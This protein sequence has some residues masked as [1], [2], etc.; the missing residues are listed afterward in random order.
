MD[1]AVDKSEFSTAPHVDFSSLLFLTR[2][3]CVLFTHISPKSGVSRSF[4]SF[5]PHGFAG[6]WKLKAKPILYF[7]Q[8]QYFPHARVIFHNCLKSVFVDKSRKN[9][10]FQPNFPRFYSH[11]R[12]LISPSRVKISRKSHFSERE[13]KF[14]SCFQRVTKSLSREN[15][16]HFHFSEYFFRRM[17]YTYI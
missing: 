2:L 4:R 16:A 15:T 12:V 11:S 8:K 7:C 5:F 17:L 10:H 13:R 9:P 14:P 3:L 6:F 1:F